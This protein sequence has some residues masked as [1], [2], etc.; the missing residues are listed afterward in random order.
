MKFA[1]LGN[2][3]FGTAMAV[4]LDRAGH[5]IAL[6]GHDAAYTA[7]IAATR[8]NPRYLEGIVLNDAIAVTHDPAVVFDRSRAIAGQSV[9]TE[10]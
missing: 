5:T 6:W 1:I 4:A 2:G 10:G 3:G 9:E 8:Q 7:Q